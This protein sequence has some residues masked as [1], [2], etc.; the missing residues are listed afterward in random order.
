MPQRQGTHV[1]FDCGCHSPK[2]PGQVA[3]APADIV[4]S[5]SLQPTPPG[6]GPVRQLA[7]VSEKVAD[8]VGEADL[9]GRLGECG[10]DRC[11]VID[12][13]LSALGHHVG[14]ILDTG[15]GCAEDPV[16]H[17]FLV[18]IPIFRKADESPGE[19]SHGRRRNGLGARRQVVLGDP[20]DISLDPGD[21]E[22]GPHV[23]QSPG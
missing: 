12:N 16:H 22:T 5:A 4:D 10:P 8:F 21:V 15:G 6:S 18:A 20:H 9:S 19:L 2:S 1:I 13:Q 14:E 7:Q 11:F 3:A 17:L 23:D